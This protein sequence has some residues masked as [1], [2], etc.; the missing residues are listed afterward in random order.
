MSINGMR[1]PPAV[2]A[3]QPAAAA[4]EAEVDKARAGPPGAGEVPADEWPD[5][6]PGRAS[7]ASIPPRAGLAMLAT[8]QAA[9]GGRPATPEAAAA[10]VRGQVISGQ[11][12]LRGRHT[13]AVLRAA[14]L[15]AA[16]G[17]T[18]LSHASRRLAG[19]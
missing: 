15:A 7:E 19:E 16:R 6:P 9:A 18:V 4:A 1:F 2:P 14:L 5:K 8:V 17:L 13:D 10:R 11:V 12:V 3:F